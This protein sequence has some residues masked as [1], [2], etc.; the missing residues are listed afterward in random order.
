MLRANQLYTRRSN[1]FISLQKQFQENELAIRDLTEQLSFAAS[2]ISRLNQVITEISD[3]AREADS[4]KIVDPNED[5]T[6]K[7]KAQMHLKES[8]LSAKDSMKNTPDNNVAS[9]SQTCL[10]S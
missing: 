7:D 5:E 3:A 1:D 10:L 8:H 4:D 9:T 6:S 2:E